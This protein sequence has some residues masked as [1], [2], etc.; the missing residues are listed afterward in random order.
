MSDESVETL[1]IPYVFPPIEGTGGR[2]QKV[3][4]KNVAVLVV[5]PK[6]PYGNVIN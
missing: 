5:V 3:K 4:E 6:E 2:S 1:N